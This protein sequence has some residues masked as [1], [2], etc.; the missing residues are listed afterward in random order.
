MPEARAESVTRIEP[1]LGWRG[2]GLREVWEYRELLYFLT[3]REVKS[4]YRQ[5]ALGPL[6][7]V[8]VPLVNTVV[9]SIIFG[10]WA[11]APHD[12]V[13]SPVYYF[14]ALL[15][16]QFFSVSASK[17]TR[18]LVD[19]LNLIS[20]VY[21]PRIIMPIA[22]AVVG[23]LDCLISFLVLLAIMAAYHVAPATTSFLLPVYLLLA[24]LTALAV[25]LWLAAAAVWFRDVAY[26]V[27]VLMQI[28]M[29]ATVI[30]PSSSVPAQWRLLYR[31]NPMQT[32]VE[33]FRW[34]LLGRGQA[35]DAVHAVTAAVVVIA[36][37]AGAYVFQRTERTVVDVL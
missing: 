29:F 26:G 18:S 35:P 25:G 2:L 9:F 7:I 37:A 24:L 1:A 27:T 5:M 31:L 33:G 36:L 11:G 3:W 20:K 10:G 13:A 8:L 34:C 22:S 28:W 21:F 32:V 17:S 30:Y 19:N 14:A 23:L 15:P 6:W 12:N 4:R 16:W